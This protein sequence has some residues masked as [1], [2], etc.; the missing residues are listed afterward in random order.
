MGTVNLKLIIYYLVKKD[1]HSLSPEIKQNIRST[2][3]V[4][5]K[6]HKEI[7]NFTLK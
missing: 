4:R 5:L 3:K 1:K 2:L 6:S 7:N